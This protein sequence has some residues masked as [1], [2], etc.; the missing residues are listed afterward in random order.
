MSLFTFYTF[1]TFRLQLRVT[2]YPLTQYVNNL[3]FPAVKFLRK[4]KLDSTRELKGVGLKP[5]NS[6][7]SISKTYTKSYTKSTDLQIN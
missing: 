4:S 6:V 3:K 1:I 2:I 7:T 5:K